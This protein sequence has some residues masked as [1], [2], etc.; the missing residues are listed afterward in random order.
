MIRQI[1]DGSSWSAHLP[2]HAMGLAIGHGRRMAEFGGA[3]AAGGLGA[4][5]AAIVTI[6]AEGRE[7][8]RQAIS[9]DRDLAPAHR[10]ASPKLSFGPA[11]P[12][13]GIS[14]GG[15]G[16]FTLSLRREPPPGIA[17]QLAAS[18]TPS[19]PRAASTAEA[20]ATL[21]ASAAGQ[22]VATVEPASAR[23]DSRHIRGQAWGHLLMRD[24]ARAAEATKAGATKPE[25]LAITAGEQ[26]PQ[27][28]TR[29]LLRRAAASTVAT[30]HQHREAHQA[31]LT[32]KPRHGERAHDRGHGHPAVQA[33]AAS[34]A[35]AELIGRDANGRGEGASV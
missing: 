15:H 4:R 10:P 34:N 33:I 24:A 19:A 6:S 7:R 32:A 5:P 18:L 2:A 22:P 14:A 25:S 1:D 23:S 12:S 9:A 30:A 11:A 17:K 27:S 31:A 26:G 29:E 8:S 21:A 13:T 16:S 28:S 35:H 20:G 3:H